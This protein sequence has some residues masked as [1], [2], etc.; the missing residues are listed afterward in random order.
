[1]IVQLKKLVKVKSIVTLLVTTIFCY[2]AATGKVSADQFM[3]IFATVI[4]F[5]YGTQANKDDGTVSKSADQ[6]KGEAEE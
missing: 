2:L 1:M 3:T 6:K 4:A 5:Y